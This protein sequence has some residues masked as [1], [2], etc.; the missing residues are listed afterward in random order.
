M[1]KLWGP[2]IKPW[3][4]YKG[5]EEKEERSRSEGMIVMQRKRQRRSENES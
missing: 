1:T 4:G 2:R 3:Y 5:D